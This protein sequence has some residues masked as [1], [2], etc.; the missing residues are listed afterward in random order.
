MQTRASYHK[1]PIHNLFDAFPEL[2]ACFEQIR[3]T[4]IP[5]PLENVLKF[6]IAASKDEAEERY[7]KLPTST[8]KIFTDGS[9]FKAG[10]GAAAWQFKQSAPNGGVFRHLHLGSDPRLTKAHILL[11]SQAAL[12]AIKTRITK[13]GRHL[14]EEFY[15]QLERLRKRC[16]S[17]EIT[18]MWIPGHRK[19]DGNEE[20]DWEV[21][22]AAERNSTPLFDKCTI[23]S[24]PIP[25]SKA[26][27][28]AAKTKQITRE[29]LVEYQTSPKAR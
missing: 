17:L 15:R 2:T 8:E 13:S 23:L 29:W 12:L 28:V 16:R 10:T 22:M 14:L 6:N 3:R 21:K 20:A 25:H 7:R 24:K 11:D 19:I 5:T 1:S 26:V 27:V 9:A 4:P 18:M